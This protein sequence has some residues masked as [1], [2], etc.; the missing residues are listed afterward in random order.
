MNIIKTNL[1]FKSNHSPMGNIE[2]IV[3]HQSGVTVLQSINVIHNY[4]KNTNGWAGIGYHF[5]VRKD[6]SIY[7]GRP[8]NLAGAH[9]P[10]A[11]NNSVGICFEGNF[12]EEIMSDAQKNAGIELIRF[13]E[14]KNDIKWIKGHNEF[15]ATSCPG[16]NFPLGEMKNVPQNVPQTTKSIVDLANEV[17]VGKYGVGE[18]RKQALGALYNEVQS[19]VNEI[20]GAKPVSNKKSNEQIAKEVINGV[21]GNGQDRKT[22]LANAGYNYNE[23][24][25]IVN[26]LLS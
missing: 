26:R 12:D 1:E 18:A 7:E 8:L 16:K 15:I 25:R 2:G 10:G 24:Q 20:L 4:H 11:N 9:C 3:V 23:I 21:W 5:Y 17:I 14:T 22:K 19:K 6:G 13:L